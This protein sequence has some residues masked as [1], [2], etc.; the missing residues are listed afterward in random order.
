MRFG[1]NFARENLQKTVLSISFTGQL[2]VERFWVSKE[3]LSSI[4]FEDT[5][6]RNRPQPVIW[7]ALENGLKI[8]FNWL[9]PVNS[10]EQHIFQFFPG[11]PLPLGSSR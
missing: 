8:M 6:F 3:L 5:S 4:V 11:C 9:E 1:G 7:Q 10:L 2:P